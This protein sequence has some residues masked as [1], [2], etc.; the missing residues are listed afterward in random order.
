MN[1]SGFLQIYKLETEHKRL[2]EDA[3]VY[4]LLQEQLKL[5]PA[6]KTVLTR[7]AYNIGS[8]RLHQSAAFWHFI[9]FSL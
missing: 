3:V 9:S 1:Q 7:L 6:Y 2:E 4:N 8:T 5:S